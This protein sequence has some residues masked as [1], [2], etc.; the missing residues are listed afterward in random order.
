MFYFIDEYK[1]WLELLLC[2]VVIYIFE[3]IYDYFP[4]SVHFVLK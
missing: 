4:Y 1:I 3:N 2:T